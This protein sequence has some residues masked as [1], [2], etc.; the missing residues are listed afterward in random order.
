MLV[1]AGTALLYGLRHGI[2]WDHLAA[3]TDLTGTQQRPRRGLLVASA[4]AGGHGL[5]VFVLGVAAILGSELLPEAVDE[6]MGRVVGVTLI[7]LAV[8]VVV[9]L[10]RDRRDFRMQSRWMLVARGAARAKRWVQYRAVEIRHDHPHDHGRGHAHTHDD[11]TAIVADPDVA[12]STT[13]ATRTTHRHEHTHV[14][15][16]PRDP[17]TTPGPLTATFVGMLHGVGA[18]TPTQVLL[19]LTAAHVAGGAAG[20]ALLACFIGGIFLSNTAVAVASS[21][22]YFNAGRRFPLYAGVAV[23]NAVA[24]LVI[25]VVFLTGGTLP[26]I[27][28]G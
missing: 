12:P 13:V 27:I 28:G 1:L 3:I 17:F 22:G 23:V 18:E 11:L 4:Y 15:L 10:V 19:F 8:S 26:A 24:S 14:G 21:F 25:G 5:V 6:A 20:V 16:M 2:D 9:G 7:V